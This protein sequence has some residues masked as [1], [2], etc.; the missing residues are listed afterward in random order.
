MT[1]HMNMVRDTIR[2]LRQNSSCIAKEFAA[3]KIQNYLALFQQRFLKEQ[4]LF[5]NELEVVIR[6]IYQAGDVEQVRGL[7]G[8]AAKKIYQRLNNVIDDDSFSLQKRDRRNPDRMNSLLNLG[9]YLL[10]SRINATARSVG[11]NPY[12]GFL[13]SPQD[14]YES[15]VCDIEELFRARI[16]RFIIRLINLKVVSRDD[17]DETERG[18]YLKRDTV[19]KFID[20]FEAEMKKKNQKNSLS[21]KEEI[22]I[23]TIVIKKWVLENGSLSFYHWEVT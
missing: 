19:R 9:Y 18:L 5:I 23:Q 22:Y 6:Q 16:D 10:F 1:S 4:Y 20:Q 2:S 15:L 17:F 3:G 7:E 11:L 21:L 14:N 12:L 13:H 8:A